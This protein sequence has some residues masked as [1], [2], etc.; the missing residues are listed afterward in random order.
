MKII[1]ENNNR[2]LC[3]DD[4]EKVNISDSNIIK[5]TGM[6]YYNEKEIPMQFIGCIECKRAIYDDTEENTETI[7]G[8]YVKPIYILDDEVW[9]KIENYTLPQQKYFLYPHLLMLPEYNYHYKIL[10]FLHTCINVNLDNFAHIT[11]NFYL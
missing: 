7:T 4:G 6:Y 5:Y 2:F 1:V 11:L 8:I 3:K 9:K 10:H